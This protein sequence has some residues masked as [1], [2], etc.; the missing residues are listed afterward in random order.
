LALVLLPTL[1]LFQ[2]CGGFSSS[3]NQAQIASTRD[4]EASGEMT[5]VQGRALYGQ[6]CA[7]CHGPIDR[8]SKQGRTANMIIQAIGNITAMRS[9]SS[10]ALLTEE[11]IRSIARALSAGDGLETGT[12]G[13]LQFTCTPG[14]TPQTPLLKLTNREFRNSMTPF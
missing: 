12:N 7:G 4:D 1:L 8:S 3:S 5:V 9:Q 2:N 11:E 10:L 13:R 14:A 6:K